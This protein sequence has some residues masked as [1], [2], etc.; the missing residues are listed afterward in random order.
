MRSYC[1]SK[2][3]EWPSCA[4]KL[5]SIYK[6]GSDRTKLKEQIMHIKELCKHTEMETTI[7]DLTEKKLFSYMYSDASAVEA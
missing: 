7:S 4:W 5:Y 3:R 2:T 1:S 6:K